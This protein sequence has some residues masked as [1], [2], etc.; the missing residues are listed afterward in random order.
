VKFCAPCTQ[1]V[2]AI[3]RWTMASNRGAALAIGQAFAALLVQALAPLAHM[4][5]PHYVG[6][7]SEPPNWIKP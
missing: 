4:C 6:K 5:C 1:P 2:R 3:R 7:T